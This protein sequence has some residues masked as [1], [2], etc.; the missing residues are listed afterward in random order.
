MRRLVR[1]LFGVTLLV[2]LSSVNAELLGGDVWLR[3][4]REDLLPFWSTPAALGNPV[5]RFPTFRCNDGTAYVPTDP[6]PELKT[7]PAWIKPEIGRDYL[8]MQ[9]RQTYV[10]AAA[11]QL[12]G[13]KRW[14]DIAK[15]GAAYTLS[16]LGPQGG[17]PSWIENGKQM[18]DE[19]ARTSQDQSYAVAG[20]AMLFYVTR[21]PE[22]EKALI[23]QQHYVFWRFW[24]KDWGMLRWVAA[25]G[26]AEEAR[27][28]E[29]VAQL[30][31]LNA[32]MLLVVPYLSEP[33]R[34]QWRADIRRLADVILN[35]YYDAASGRFFGSLDRPDSRLPGG[36]HN[37]FGHTIKSYWM[38]LL[39]A[40][41]L[42]DAKLEAFAKE[43][44]AKVLREAWDD[45]SRTWRS[46]WRPH[47]IDTWKSWWIFAE[48]DQMAATLA[49]DGG[50]EAKYLGS[51]WPFWLKFLVDRRNGEV[52]DGVSQ[53]GRANANS[54]KIHHWK[55]GFHSW[56]HAL[57]SYLAAQGLAG[58][59][60]TL[61]FATGNSK[62][63]FRPYVLPGAVESVEERDGVEAVRFRMKR[64]RTGLLR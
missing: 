21:E 30:D 31:Q 48:L 25:D 60:A 19:A 40:R 3:H 8:R 34:S 22:L 64:A 4:A 26:P 2:A 44:G 39:A 47:G 10:Y 5:G 62:S 59:P 38:L 20:L 28:K 7:P 16:Q 57:V 18:P 50:D 52:W 14:L 46:V 61:Y 43:G 56:E 29:L 23:A 27:R 53:E 15:A 32:Y 12:T 54:P 51:S 33:A 41:E 1:C 11:F 37:D 42:G 36:R 17:Y 24:D 45:R 58:Q 6:C 35:N 63:L 55:N 9:G 49:L 13:D